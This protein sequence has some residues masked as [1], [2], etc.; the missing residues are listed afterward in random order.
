MENIKISKA[1]IKDDLFLVGE[2]TEELPGHSKKDSKFTCTVP[3]HNDLKEAFAK[4][5]KH[6]AIVCDELDLPGKVKNLDN[7]D[8][9]E[10][11]KFSVR[12]FTIGGNDENEGC[13]ISG[14]KEGKYGIVN[15]N[16]PF[17]KWG[18]S[19]YKHISALS[20]D[21]ETCVYE[22]EQ[23]LFSGKR[24]PEQ[25]LE[26]EFDGEGDEANEAK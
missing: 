14:M 25:Q 21:I 3:V 11:E 16:S 18:A 23:Y 4:L 17:Q 22:V 1:S 2:Y 13:T 12:G 26:L 15:L 6:L 9:P 10:L 24:A 8:A 5:T 7:W 19:E 20:S